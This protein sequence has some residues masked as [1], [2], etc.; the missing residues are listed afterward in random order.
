METTCF[1]FPS[2]VLSAGLLSKR[3]LAS[4]QSPSSEEGELRGNRRKVPWLPS[5]SNY[6]PTTSPSTK[7]QQVPN[8]NS[9]TPS[10]EQVKAFIITTRACVWVICRNTGI[11]PA[12][13][14]VRP[15]LKFLPNIVYCGVLLPMCR[16][17]IKVSVRAV[18][19]L[20]KPFALH[21]G[22][23]TNKCMCT[24]AVIHFQKVSTLSILPRLAW[25]CS[26]KCF[27]NTTWGM[28]AICLQSA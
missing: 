18:L 14:K 12:K 8:N 27:R 2:I 28:H 3:A 23:I 20:L 16:V 22:V 24:I 13:G 9:K 1:L 15:R 21:C 19:E 17:R 25:D 10:S 7:G 26:N 4:L 11:L 5:A 6:P